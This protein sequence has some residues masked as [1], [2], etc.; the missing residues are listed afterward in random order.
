[1][2]LLFFPVKKHVRINSARHGY[3]DEFKDNY[4]T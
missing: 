3:V 4:G 1:M 2:L